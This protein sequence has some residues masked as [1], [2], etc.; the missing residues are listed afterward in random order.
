[1]PGTVVSQSARTWWYGYGFLSPLSPRISPS[2]SSLS[3]ASLRLLFRGG[4]LP[5]INAARNYAKQNTDGS[6]SWRIGE[7]GE[8]RIAAWGTMSPPTGTD[9]HR[10]APTGTDDRQAP[11]DCEIVWI[12]YLTLVPFPNCRERSCVPAPSRRPSHSCQSN[13]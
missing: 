11:T 9:R 10:Q 5:V 2:L 4:V 7:V 12:Q 6:G 8:L 13:A 1:M 3:L